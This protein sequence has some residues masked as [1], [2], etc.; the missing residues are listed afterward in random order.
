MID[1]P[2]SSQSTFS[3]KNPGDPIVF[4]QKPRDRGYDFIGVTKWFAERSDVILFFFDPDKPGTTGETLDVLTK[5]LPGLEY[6]LHII[7]NKA[8]QF[9]KVIFLYII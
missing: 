8:D 3:T 2:Q 7:L 9:T 5:S 1:N 6:K 4:D